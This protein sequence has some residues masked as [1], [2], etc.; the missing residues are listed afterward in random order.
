LRLG[1][2]AP[3]RGPARKLAGP[4]LAKKQMGE[5]AQHGGSGRG[6]CVCVFDGQ[7]QCVLL[8]IGMAILHV[9]VCVCLHVCAMHEAHGLVSALARRYL[10][11]APAL[12]RPLASGRRKVHPTGLPARIPCGAF[13]SVE[14]PNVSQSTGWHSGTKDSGNPWPPKQL[15]LP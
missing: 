3:N 8:L 13:E 7:R 11:V 10:F 1:P 4:E 14:L 12:P 9:C 15:R 2:P 5:N 6:V